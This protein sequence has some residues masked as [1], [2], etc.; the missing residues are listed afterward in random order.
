M[1]TDA[2][3]IIQAHGSEL[4]GKLKVGDVKWLDKLIEIRNAISHQRPPDPQWVDYLR[5]EVLPIVN[6]GKVSLGL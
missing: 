4:Q 1:P 6:N 3:L 2:K 5:Q